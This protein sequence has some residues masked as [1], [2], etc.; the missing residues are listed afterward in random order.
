MNK[1]QPVIE[2]RFW[3]DRLS[4][5]W[6]F[7]TRPVR[8]WLRT[9]MLR[10]VEVEVRGG[11]RVRQILADGAGVMITPNHSSHSDVLVVYELCAHLRRCFHIMT[12][13]QIFA[14]NRWPVRWLLQRHGCF[15]VDR[16]GADVRAFKR[17]VQILKDSPNP[18]LIFPEGEVYHLNDYVSPFREGPAVMAVLAA[19]RADRPVYCVPCG[20]KYSYVEDPTPELL[21]LMARLEQRAKWRLQS[22]L[23][24]EERIIKFSVGQLALKEVEYLSA[25]QTG[26]RRER[27][28]KLREV[29]LA[30]LEDRH[31]LN[32]DQKTVPERIKEIRR[33]C[34]ERLQ[35][36]DLP[37][38]EQMSITDD[39][40]DV[41]VVVQLYSYLGDYLEGSSSVERLA[42][43]LDKLEEDVMGIPYAQVR[44][45]RRA[46]VAL[47]D[48]IDVA[49]FNRDSTR[50]A[51]SG[52][53]E[54]LE[55]SVQQ[56]VDR[57]V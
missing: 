26:S 23:T 5:L 56:L 8:W 50:R 14:I 13:A 36:E 21:E 42:E 27:L 39:L 54:E 12:A 53:T 4:P 7:L 16:A 1:L 41:F 38:M 19:R 33:S 45:T 24:L 46:V 29:I 3:K 31:R 2:K 17:G 49:S 48:P 20:I 10:L 25:P 52:L 32:A 34:V 40:H 11:E 30:G 18:L 57:L 28:T 43:T 51:A 15:S 35:D 47:G 44:G 55:V 37:E 6:V 22:D 9:H